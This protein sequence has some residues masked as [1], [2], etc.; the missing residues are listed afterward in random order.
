MARLFSEKKCRDTDP[1]YRYLPSSWAENEPERREIQ[2][3]HVLSMSSGLEPYDGPYEAES[4]GQIIANLGVIARPGTLWWYNTGALDLMNYVIADRSGKSMEDYLNSEILRPIGGGKVFVQPRHKFG[5]H[6]FCSFYEITPRDYAR[7][8]YLLLRGG[9][10]G[11]KQLIEKSVVSL[12]TSLPP[13]LPEAEVGESGRK[14]DR[15]QEHYAYTF[16]LNRTG[17]IPALPPDAYMASGGNHKMIVV[18]S[19]DTVIVRVGNYVHDS[20]PVNRVYGM[21]RESLKEVPLR[22]G[23]EASTSAPPP[24]APSPAPAPSGSV[25]LTEFKTVPSGAHLEI[26]AESGICVPPMTVGADPGDP[27]TKYV[28]TPRQAP[29]NFDQGG[30]PAKAALAFHVPR[31]QAYSIWI[32]TI[33]PDSRSD[34]YILALDG[35]V[36]EQPWH[37][38]VIPQS[39][40]WRWTRIRNGRVIEAGSHVLEFRHRE[41]G[42]KLDKVI[43]TTD[44]DYEP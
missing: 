20:A 16:W 33:A 22:A 12:V 5:G 21:I 25:S 35:S 9:Q 11:G 27:S 18:P 36:M 17:L 19:L 24:A 31:T 41:S 39:K 38:Q 6:G 7:I 43:I 13:W 10:W 14:R 8:G 2:I 34:S 37:T 3:R 32:R 4:Y 23:A 1:L 44:P 40:D 26:E 29:P 15:P 42:I 30:G 28:W